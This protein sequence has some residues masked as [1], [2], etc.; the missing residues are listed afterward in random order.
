MSLKCLFKSV[1]CAHW[2]PQG[3]PSSLGGVSPP[4]LAGVSP[5]QRNLHY[6]CKCSDHPHQGDSQAVPSVG[7]PPARW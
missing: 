6:R 3:C 4:T 5:P 2:T 1:R 7:L